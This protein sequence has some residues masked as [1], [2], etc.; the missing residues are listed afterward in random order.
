[1][2]VLSALSGC[3]GREPG[4]MPAA[5]G[6]VRPGVEVLL[7]DSIAILEG[8]RVGLVTN[9]SGVDR[10]GV[11]E[12]DRLR[13]AGVNLV[14]L[15]SPEHGLRGTAGPGMSVESA[16]DA[17]TGLPI[18]SLYGQTRAPSDSVLELLD[19]LLIDLPDVGARFYTY[20]S[21]MIEVMKAAGR[22][23][24]PVVVLDRPNP[25]GG[26]MQGTVLDSAYRSS[27][28]Y[29]VMPIRHGLTLGELARLA[30]EELRIPVRLSVMPVAG[31]R[32]SMPF[33]MTGLPFVRPSPNLRDLEALFHYPGTC[34]FEATA[35]SVGRGT[36]FAFRQ[37]GAPWLDPER[38]IAALDPVDHLG[39]LLKPVR[40]TPVA[41]GDD[42]KHAGIEVP[43]IRLHLIDPDAYDPVRTAVALLVAIQRIYPDQIG[44][45]P[46]A[47][48]R[49]SGG[50]ELREAIVAGRSASEI[51]AG[52]RGPLDAFRSATESIRLY[53]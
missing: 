16:V 2:L 46:R 9:Q 36:D 51:V 25:L 34:L 12:I 17:A 6:L 24:I 48:D 49:L 42:A 44:W 40:F 53:P 39:V 19:V 23:D 33:V 30:R 27:V 41:S 52:W 8:R 13:A 14:V 47:F 18:Y 4:L 50:P 7:T 29:L 32:R 11:H 3:A 5:V 15:F 35:L 1:V 26:A 31:W 43:G 20:Y 38:V 45:I 22:K 37:I 10:A 21:T 28:G